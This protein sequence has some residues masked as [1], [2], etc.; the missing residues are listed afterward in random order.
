M[1]HIAIAA[2]AILL[3]AVQWFF[4]HFPLWLFAA[5]MN[6]LV[7]ILW[8]VAVWEGFRH[9][10]SS[11]MAKFLLSTEATYLAL[12]IAAAIALV[13]GLQSEP[14]TASWPVVGGFAYVLTV[15]SFVI[16]RGWRSERGVRWRFVCTHLG[17]WL[18]TLSL[19]VGAADKQILRIEVGEEPTREAVNERGAA[20]FLD[21]E[22]A[23]SDFKVEHSKS[24]S[25]ERFCATIGIDGKNVDIEVNTPYSYRYGED[26]Y[27]VDYSPKSCVLQVV[28]EPWRAVTALGIGLLVLGAFMLFLQGFQR[29]VK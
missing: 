24:G 14:T 1:P 17:L 4:G 27:L 6:L 20:S 29:E 12:F 25:P 19:F 2:L 26:I 10:K 3:F 23:L 28:R 15:L 21:Y 11:A 13:L 16:L 22:I 18:A 8:L 9:R 7:V 5:P